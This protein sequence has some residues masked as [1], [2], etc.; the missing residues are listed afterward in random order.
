[1]RIKVLLFAALRERA[2]TGEL[3]LDLPDGATVADAARAL[4]ERAAA[5]SVKGAM[6]AVNEVYARPDQRLGDG[7]VVAFIPPVAGGQSR[8]ESVAA[9]RSSRAAQ[10]PGRWG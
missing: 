2:G 6:A 1:V 9:C 5:L 10:P 8:R 4:A 3:E 7:D